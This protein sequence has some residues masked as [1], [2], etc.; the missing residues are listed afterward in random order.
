M[1][2]ISIAYACVSLLLLGFISK[3][4][5]GNVPR[6]MIDTPA[7]YSYIYV[8]KTTPLE[9]QRSM[10][11]LQIVLNEMGRSMSVDEANTYRN[12][13]FRQLGRLSGRITLDSIKIKKP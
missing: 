1:T 8:I 4:K 2:K 12:A 9:W 11:T 7:K 6:A 3:Q 10:D 5:E 13:A